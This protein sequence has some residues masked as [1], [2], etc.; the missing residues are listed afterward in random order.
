[1]LQPA[2]NH[3]GFNDYTHQSKPGNNDENISPQID[4]CVQAS[5]THQQQMFTDK[6]PF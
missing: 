3:T 5:T 1:L 2:G 6:L 4:S